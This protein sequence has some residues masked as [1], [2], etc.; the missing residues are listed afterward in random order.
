LVF[1]SVKTWV[2]DIDQQ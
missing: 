1:A 2:E